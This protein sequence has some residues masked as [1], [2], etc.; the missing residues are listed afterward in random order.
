[1]SVPGGSQPRP[2]QPFFPALLAIAPD[3]PV[4]LLF[5]AGSGM[6]VE[7]GTDNA[8][9]FG[10]WHSPHACSSCILAGCLLTFGSLGRGLWFSDIFPAPQT[11]DREQKS[12]SG[13]SHLKVGVPEGRSLGNNDFVLDGGCGAGGTSSPLS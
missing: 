5:L 9:P 13:Q 10:T 3:C 12:R 11:S 8:A 4:S 7:G 2:A 6:D 1:M